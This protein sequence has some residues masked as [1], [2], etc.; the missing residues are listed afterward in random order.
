MAEHLQDGREL[1]KPNSGVGFGVFDVQVRTGATET[2]GW[3]GVWGVWC[4]RFGRG[5]DGL[6]VLRVCFRAS[7]KGSNLYEP[8]VGENG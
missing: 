8:F 1:V 5:L 3:F 4:V 7:S 6:V 2:R